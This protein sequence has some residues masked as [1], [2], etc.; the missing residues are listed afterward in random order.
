MFRKILHFING[1]DPDSHTEPADMVHSRLDRWDRGTVPVAG[2]QN[3]GFMRALA[4]IDGGTL[5]YTDVG[6]ACTTMRVPS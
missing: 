4:E 6:P 1:G 2:A 3:D 5:N